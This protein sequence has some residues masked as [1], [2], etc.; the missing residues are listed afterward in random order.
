MPRRPSEPW[1]PGPAACSRDVLAALGRAATSLPGGKGFAVSTHVLRF[2]PV[3]DAPHLA[4]DRPQRRVAEN[5]LI[6]KPR[7]RQPDHRPGRRL[8]AMRAGELIQAD[9]RDT[10]AG[11]EHEDRQ[12]GDERDQN[13]DLEGEH[14]HQREEEVNG[15]QGLAA[16]KR[17]GVSGGP[18]LPAGGQH[19]PGP[20]AE[21]LHE[22]LVPPGT[23]PDELTQRRR[24]LLLGDIPVV[25]DHPDP[26]AGAGQAQPDVGVLGQVLL[27]P[28]A[29][30]LE[31]LAVEKDR[32]PSQRGGADAGVVVQAALEPEEVLKNVQRR[33]PAG[34][35]VHQLHAGLDDLDVLFFH[36]RV[37]HV[38]DVGMNVVFGV[39]DGDHV[40]LGLRQGGVQP[41]RLVDGLVVEH[42][43]RDVA[44]S[45]P[46]QLLDLGL[47]LGDG[48]LVVRGA[49]HQNLDQVRRVTRPYDTLDRPRDDGFLVPGGKHDGERKHG[50]QEV[51]WR[52][53]LLWRPVPGVQRQ[54]QSMAGLKRDQQREKHQRCVEQTV[55]HASRAQTQRTLNA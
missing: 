23:L 31:Q 29:D 25:V 36:H 37:H 17:Q 51:L 48:A 2:L 50:R 45:F 39:E 11:N 18:P 3:A 41:V 16:R 55:H 19:L 42:H 35:E 53:R 4:L 52:L 27:V 8:Q 20:L 22:P 9:H 7:D 43:H 32:V 1:C 12:P 34:I 21:R 30:V 13:R 38:E 46:P 44:V 5:E 6:G 14:R 47:G 26:L 10:E 24:G 28:S 54:I 49:D 33:V 15:Q 40:V